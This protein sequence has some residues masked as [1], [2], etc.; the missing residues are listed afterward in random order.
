MQGEQKTF[1]LA[2]IYMR[3]TFFSSIFIL[4]FYIVMDKVSAQILYT[5]RGEW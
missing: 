2:V 1:T 5:L 3:C 4:L